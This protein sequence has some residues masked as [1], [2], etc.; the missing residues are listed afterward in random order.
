MCDGLEDKY[1]PFHFLLYII[2]ETHSYTFGN[3]ILNINE[4]NEID[5]IQMCMTKNM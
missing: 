2:S 5:T 4:M 3:T 1:I